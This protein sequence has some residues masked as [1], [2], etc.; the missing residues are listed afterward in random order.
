MTAVGNSFTKL[1]KHTFALSIWALL[2]FWTPG[3]RRR[4]GHHWELWSFT[5]TLQGRDGV[6]EDN[7]FSQ[8]IN[9][10]STER[11]FWGHRNWWASPQG[12]S[13]AGEEGTLSL[14]RTGGGS[15]WSLP[16][17]WGAAGKYN[18]PGFRDSSPM[19]PEKNQDSGRGIGPVCG[20]QQ[21]PARKWWKERVMSVM[22]LTL[23]FPKTQPHGPAGTCSRRK[24]N[25]G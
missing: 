17:E 16:S 21:S 8:E 20:G 19:F 24:K 13:A 9:K 12:G 6:Q 7:L 11:R 4:G 23:W 14:Q 1:H 5:E 18:Y 3:I 22:A 15:M 25:M 2:I 10:P